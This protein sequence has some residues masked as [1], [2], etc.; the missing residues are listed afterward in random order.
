VHVQGRRRRQRRLLSF[1]V[2][3]LKP[4]VCCLFRSSVHNLFSLGFFG[5]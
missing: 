3:V 2:T 5:I 1:S 4:A